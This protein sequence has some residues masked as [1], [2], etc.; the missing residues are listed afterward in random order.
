MGWTIGI[1]FPAGV[2]MVFSSFPPRS[3][4][5]WNQPSILSN[6]YRGLSQGDKTAGV[7]N[8]QITSILCWG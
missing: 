5:L 3:G 1:Q 4:W 2:V 7:W 6:W 8:W